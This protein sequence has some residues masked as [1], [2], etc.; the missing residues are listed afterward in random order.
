[1]S[2]LKSFCFLILSVSFVHAKEERFV[3]SQKGSS[4]VCMKGI[5]V[6]AEAM[7]AENAKMGDGAP[8]TNQFVFVN[9]TIVASVRTE[10][11]N[12]GNFK[13]TILI[14]RKGLLPNSTTSA[15][16]ASRQAPDNLAPA[17]S[18]WFPTRS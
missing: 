6:V 9:K 1:M 3:W 14:G 18:P 16:S 8:F 17:I 13:H 2:I 4:S 12:D 5:E 7:K 10:S 11:T 15:E